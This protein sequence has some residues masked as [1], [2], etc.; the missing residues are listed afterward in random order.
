MACPLFVLIWGGPGQMV[1]DTCGFKIETDDLNQEGVIRAMADRMIR[2]A[3][4]PALG[5]LLSNGATRRVKKFSWS[6]PVAQ[7]YSRN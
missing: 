6:V 7:E 4:D 1:D 3:E 2:L 5:R